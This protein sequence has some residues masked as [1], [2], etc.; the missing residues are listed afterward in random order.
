MI[1][2]G[3]VLAGLLF[4]APTTGAAQHREAAPIPV[5]MQPSLFAAERPTP[6]PGPSLRMPREDRVPGAVRYAA[7][8]AL[9]GAALGF[10][11]YLIQENTV[12]HTNHEMDPLVRFGSVSIGALVGAVVG[13][14]V[15]DRRTP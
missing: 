1:I 14:V 3:V 11:A 15:H 12:A 5:Y 8:G 13:T 2:R 4:V 10:G 9:A 7:A 6:A